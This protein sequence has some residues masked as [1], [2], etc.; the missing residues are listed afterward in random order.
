MH[1]DFL[2]VGDIVIIREGM[3]IPVDGLVL[4]AN[5][6]TV[7]EA[8]MTGES[9]ELRKD[10]APNCFSR[11]EDAMLDRKADPKAVMSEHD[12]HEI[13]SPLLLSGTN[14]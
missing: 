8:A 14:V 6:L 5:Q 13:P 4:A 11:Y 10:T 7:S 1:H 12:K 9:D 3:Y 2:H